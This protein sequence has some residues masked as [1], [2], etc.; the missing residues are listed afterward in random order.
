[1]QSASSPRT[2]SNPRFG[3]IYKE[4]EAVAPTTSDRKESERSTLESYLKRLS[5][6]HAT[7]EWVEV[8]VHESAVFAF[9]SRHRERDIERLFRLACR[10]FVNT[11]IS[12][13][14]DYGRQEEDNYLD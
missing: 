14:S 11:L 10:Y 9:A 2:N 4:I 8:V 5:A 13:N 6:H 1:M 3:K 7:A 12:K